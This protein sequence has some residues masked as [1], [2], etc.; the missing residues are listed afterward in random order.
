VSNLVFDSTA[1]SHFAR[2]GRLDDL[3]TITATDECVVPAEVLDEL[4]RGVA[5]YPAL[6]TVA[7]QGWLK[8]VQLEEL[9][10]LVAFATYK[11]E[12][13]GGAERNNGEASVLAW[14]NA[15]GGIAVI[16]ESAA[17]SI[18]DATGITVHGSLWLVIRG[19]KSRVLDRATAEGIVDDLI[20]TG[21]RLPVTDGAALFA[22]AYEA[23][24]LP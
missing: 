12:L 19:F 23:G 6:G 11:A 9:G 17:T 14:A 5:A 15:H 10:E 8:A 1:L 3:E 18:G 13:G 24:L 21:M 4:A 20:S 7:S 22:Y 16:D 2:A